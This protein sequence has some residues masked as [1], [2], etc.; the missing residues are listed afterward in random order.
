M[1]GAPVSGERKPEMIQ[2]TID[3][4]QTEVAPG[5]TIL[6]AA[7]QAGVAIPALCHSPLVEAYGVCRVCSVE[8]DE[9][10]RKRI[11][12]ACNYPLHKPVAVFT[13]S[14]RALRTRGLVLEM[15]LARWPQVKV[16]QD[17]AR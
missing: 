5:T 7:K 10:R 12:T 2:V 15:M 1:S 17:L 4:R 16:V 11:V 9:G 8:V 6:A 13:R 14:E 3:G